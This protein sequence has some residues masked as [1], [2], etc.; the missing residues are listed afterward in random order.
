MPQTFREY[1]ELKLLTATMAG[2][3]ASEKLRQ[4]EEHAE[5]IRRH[6]SAGKPLEQLEGRFVIPQ[7]RVKS[8][9]S[10]SAVLA[11][12]TM[13]T[14]ATYSYKS[15][16]WPSIRELNDASGTR[17]IRGRSRLFP[18]QRT[19][20]LDEES[21]AKAK[22]NGVPPSGPS[23]RNEYRACHT[24]GEWALLSVKYDCLTAHEVEAQDEP[25]QE[26]ERAEIN[27]TVQGLI[28]Q[29]RNM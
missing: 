16:N 19:N 4:R 13:W 26:L 29:I 15:T 11:Q 3:V 20:E 27:E 25:P 12:P 2:K 17:A 6:I 5:A 1:I 18:A 8:S 23:E 21:V 24:I 7:S 9:G 10:L 14:D 28:E 22:R